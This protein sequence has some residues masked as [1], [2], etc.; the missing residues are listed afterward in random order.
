M[1]DRYILVLFLAFSFVLQINT[2]FSEK[3][4]VLNEV[5]KPER[6]AVGNGY[7]Y[8][9]EKT[10]IHI[11]DQ[12]T[13]K[14]VGKFGKEGEGPRE[15]K[16]NMFGAPIGITPHKGKIIITSSAK[17]SFYTA[18]GKYISEQRVAQFDNFYPFGDKYICISQA[19]KKGD[20]ATRV[21]AL[22]IAD[23]QLKKGKVIYKSNF[24]VG[25]NFKWEFPITPFYPSATD[26]KV[27]VIDGKKGFSINIYDKDGNKIGRIFKDVKKVKIP[28]S[29]KKNTIKWFKTN[30]N[31]KNIWNF[32]KTRISFKKFY[33]QIFNIFAEKN[34]LYIFTNTMKGELRECIITDLKGN[35]IKRKFFYS[36]ENYGMNFKF[37]ADLDNN[38]YYWI[39]ENEDDETWDLYREKIE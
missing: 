29:Y 27:F 34:R 2:L 28:D 22:F 24:E 20:N 7:I 38:Y 5:L 37:M 17:V 23:K 15:I 13:Y 30:P 19:E 35:E 4:S 1:K 16:K 36:P 31:Y 10:T 39:V 32:F 3:L 6:F 8:V 14:Y 18:T 25:M 33:P 11:Y 9:L 21:L 26:D 12:K